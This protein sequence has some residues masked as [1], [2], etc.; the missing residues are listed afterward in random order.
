[1]TLNHDNDVPLQTKSASSLS[2]SSSTVF[3]STVSATISIRIEFS[4]ES[5]SFAFPSS[6][7][8]SRPFRKINRKEGEGE[9]GIGEVSLIRH[10]HNR[11]VAAPIHFN[12]LGGEGRRWR[13]R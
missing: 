6:D 9:R 7:R 12:R 3:F 4:P 13:N 1:M 8:E 11:P 10:A 2:L 5:F